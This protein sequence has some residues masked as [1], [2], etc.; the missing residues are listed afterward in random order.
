MKLHIQDYTLASPIGWACTFLIFAILRIA[1]A[2]VLD[3]V[4]HVTKSDLDVYDALARSLLAGYGYVLEPDGAPLL[5][6]PPLYPLFLT[7]VWG[8]AGGENLT[9]VMIVQGLVDAASAVLVLSLGRRQ[10]GS[11]VG[12]I[13]ALI[14]VAYPLSVYYTLRVMSESLFTLTL[15]L[16]VVAL[17]RALRDPDWRWYAMLGVAG[18][19]NALVRPAGMYFAPLC[20]LWLLVVHRRQ[21]ARNSA[22]VAVS[23]LSFALTTSPWTWRNYQVTGE[24]LPVATGGGYSLWVGN[25]WESLG[26][27][28]DQLEGKMQVDYL[29]ERGAIIA[30]VA[31]STGHP[32]YG[33]G[34]SVAEDR[35]FGREALASM[36]AHPGHTLQ[37]FARKFTYLWFDV[38]QIDSRIAQRQV[39][40]FQ[41]ALLGLAAWGLLLA[42]RRRVP[43]CLFLLPIGYFI[44]LHTLVVAT[45]RYSVPLVPLLAILV[46]VAVEP[47]ARWLRRWLMR[48]ERA[49]TKDPTCDSSIPRCMACS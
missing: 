4:A 40:V 41:A 15:L 32:P 28:D 2:V 45:V 48:R 13:A 7:A 20:A 38:Y 9:A 46:A 31:R 37:L 39:I 34:L 8:L 14:F 30:R 1:A 19:L 24:F 47:G 33:S 49:A 6:R 36:R 16:V 23:L 11:V 10:F 17:D 42:A 26:R 21:V 44:G 43:L 27:E 35:E 12:V 5:W 3:S 22:W 29:R 25:R 18:G